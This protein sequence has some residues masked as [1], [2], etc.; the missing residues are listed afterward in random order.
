MCPAEDEDLWP[1]TTPTIK[2]YMPE[3]HAMTISKR[4]LAMFVLALGGGSATGL[5]GGACRRFGAASARNGAS[6]CGGHRGFIYIPK[7]FFHKTE[8]LFFTH[9]PHKN[10]NTTILTN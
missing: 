10:D 5:G 9:S 7:D 2:P 8:I 1:M 3:F 4:M 6:T